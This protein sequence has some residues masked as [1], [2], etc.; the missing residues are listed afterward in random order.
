MPG[1]AGTEGLLLHWTR[2]YALEVKLS[3]EEQNIT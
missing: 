2:A 3:F 1:V